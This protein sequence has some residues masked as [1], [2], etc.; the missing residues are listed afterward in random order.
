VLAAALFAVNVVTRLVTRFGFD[1]ERKAEDRAS[2]VM[3]TV[4]GLVLAVVAFTRARRQPLARW[5]TDVAVAVVTA[6]L[7][8]IFVGPF[9]SGGTPFA[10]GAGEFFAQVWLYAAFAGVGTLVGYLLVTALGWD[11]RSQSLKR[12]A[13]SRMAKP[14]RVVRR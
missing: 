6:M 2:L 5:S 14:R 10:N 9:V 11:Y 4:I 8:T 1:G 13:E 7:L 3:F 12:F